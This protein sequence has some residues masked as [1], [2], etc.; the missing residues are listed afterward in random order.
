MQ[1]LENYFYTPS[2]H[3]FYELE[4]FLLI[5]LQGL[6]YKMTATVTPGTI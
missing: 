2:M 3:G 5:R 6:I 4:H 1:T